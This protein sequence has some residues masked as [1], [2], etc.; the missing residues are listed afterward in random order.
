MA[1]RQAELFHQL[2]QQVL[3]EVGLQRASMR[4]GG[5]AAARALPAVSAVERLVD[6]TL[7]EALAE[8]AS[9]LHFEPQTGG[10][11]IRVPRGRASSGTA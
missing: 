3:R 7:G 8:G 10:V 2:V 9:D 11:R 5:P 4:A 6:F 1:E